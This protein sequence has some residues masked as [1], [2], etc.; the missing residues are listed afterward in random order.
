MQPRILN[1]YYSTQNKALLPKSIGQR[2]L[3]IA[4]ALSLYYVGNHTTKALPWINAEKTAA[5][6]ISKNQ[7]L[8]TLNEIR[9]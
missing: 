5:K 4:L 2:L 1:K 3:N 6:T 7:K 8:L 9:T